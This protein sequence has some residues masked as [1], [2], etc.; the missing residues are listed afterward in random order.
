MMILQLHQLLTNKRIK[1][2]SLSRYPRQ[3]I[4]SSISG[5]G[6]CFILD[7][8]LSTQLSKAQNKVTV[9][10]SSNFGQL[11][12]STLNLCP[13]S[14]L[15]IHFFLNMTRFPM[16]LYLEV[17]LKLV[18]LVGDSSFLPKMFTTNSVLYCESD[19][20]IKFANN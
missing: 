9:S 13:G 20:E 1:S 16:R 8:V 5:Q 18:L 11:F 15:S 19:T 4:I 10:L 12:E 7:Q 6:P 2:N 3:F 17:G 14:H